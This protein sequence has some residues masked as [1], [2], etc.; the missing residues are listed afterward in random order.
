VVGLSFVMPLDLLFSCWFFYIFW[1]AEA[2]LLSWIGIAPS[3]GHYISQQ[4]T[5]GYLAIAAGALWVS[6]RH[7]KEVFRKVAGMPSELSDAG[8][9]MSY[10][11]AAAGVV[12][13]FLAMV[14]FSWG[15][16]MS[17]WI[18]VI[19][20]AFY[21]GI[22]VGVARMRATCG[23]PAHD[24]HFA[25]PDEILAS[26]VGTANLGGTSL[27]VM[28]LFFGFNRAYR[29]HPMAHSL[30]GFKLAERTRASQRKML[31]IQMIAVV[32][33]C[34][35]A[36]WAVLH[37]SYVSLTGAPWLLT[38]AFGAEPYRRLES[39]LSHPTQSSG[40]S[41][42]FYL[43]GFLIVLLMPLLKLI[44]LEIPFHPIG[45]A[46]STSWSMDKVWFPIFIAWCAKSLIIK[47]QG[48]AGYRRYLP[49]FMGLILG[50]YL[51]GGLWCLAALAA[52]KGMYA[53]WP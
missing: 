47:Y 15:A 35:C 18:A 1:K 20:F 7:L 3:L 23:P 26:T 8:E 25:G 52:G 2:I 6:R 9:P 14:G 21:F 16:G 10:R 51:V 45:F 39:W 46:V 49:L 5:G 42:L 41:A 37:L 32:V 27:G 50:D 13:G 43:L 29:G 38:K 12:L 34:L 4:A 30:E 24:L 48:A 36:F 44:S 17:P 19:F 28:T 22:S 31:I 53:F 11:F 33:G 40:T